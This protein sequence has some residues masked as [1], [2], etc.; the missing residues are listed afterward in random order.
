MNVLAMAA[1]LL[2][3]T[4]EARAA[5]GLTIYSLTFMLVAMGSVTLLAAWCFIRI[6]GGKAHFDPDG[7]GPAR[8]P[9][10]GSADP[11]D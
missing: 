11:P 3:S 1:M 2:Q 8:P 5:D 4:V 9:V 10:S 6:L 7:T